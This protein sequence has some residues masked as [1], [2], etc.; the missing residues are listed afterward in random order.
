[1]FDLYIMESC[2]YCQKVM[3]YLDEKGINYRKYDINKN[4]DYKKD[5]IAI[6]GKEQVPFLYNEETDDR[7]YESDKIIEYLKIYDNK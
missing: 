5:L 6:G 2:P 3:A 4:S 1:M 7:L